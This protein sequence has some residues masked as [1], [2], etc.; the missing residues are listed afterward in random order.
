MVA[1]NQ[2]RNEKLTQIDHIN[3]IALYHHIGKLMMLTGGISSWLLTK[4]QCK[5]LTDD[6]LLTIPML[7]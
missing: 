5:E 4:N 2:L 6:P 3:I 7:G 1:F